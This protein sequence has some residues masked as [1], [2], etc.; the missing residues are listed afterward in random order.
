MGHKMKT[1]VFCCQNSAW[2]AINNARAEG[3]ELPEMVEYIPVPCSERVNIG[4]ILKT[5]ESE[6]GGILILGCNAE[7]CFNLYGNERVRIRV[8]EARY[9][10]QKRGNLPVPI[11]YYEI[12]S[13]DSQK[14]AKILNLFASTTR[15]A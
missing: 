14:V 1:V 4:L 15:E 2:K 12:G 3:M 11:E 6:V 7:S 10:L 8:A 13:D 5:V 9:M